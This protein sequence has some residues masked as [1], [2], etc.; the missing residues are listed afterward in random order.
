MKELAKAMLQAHNEMPVIENNAVNP[1]FRSNYA[2]LDTIIKQCRPVFSKHGIAVLEH[3]SGDLQKLCLIHAESGE[4]LNSSIELRCKDVS[5]P[6]QLKS[7]QTYARR[8]LW[9]SATGVCPVDEDDDGNQ[10]SQG[11]SKPV[12]QGKGKIG[13]PQKTVEAFGAEG[14]IVLSYLVSVKAIKV[15]QGFDDVQKWRSEIIADPQKI[16]ENARQHQIN[17]KG[18]K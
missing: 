12:T 2:T 13:L 8:M 11:D 17:L 7:A 16:L 5:N 14:E 3:S 6:Q 9:L 4:Q 18:K 1:H 10:A 15:G